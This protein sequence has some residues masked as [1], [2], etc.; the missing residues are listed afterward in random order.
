MFFELG[1][2]LY[3]YRGFVTG[4]AKIAAAITLVDKIKR[5]FNH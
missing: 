5:K 2:V 4:L 3:S 1:E